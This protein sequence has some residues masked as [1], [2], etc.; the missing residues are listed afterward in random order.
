MYV[1][2]QYL[3]MISLRVFFNHLLMLNNPMKRLFNIEHVAIRVK[4]FVVMLPEK[5]PASL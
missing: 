1:Y 4:C 3:S 5:D 2:K